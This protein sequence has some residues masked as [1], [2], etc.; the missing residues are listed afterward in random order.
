MSEDAP[1]SP[2]LAAMR[3]ALAQAEAASAA[4]QARKA[5]EREPEP[6][7]AH[8]AWEAWRELALEEDA[9]E[10]DED[11]AR[12]ARAAADALPEPEARS[13]DPE[14]VVWVPSEAEAPEPWYEARAR[15]AL[16][17]SARDVP[18]AGTVPGLLTALLVEL[19]DM[20]RTN[21]MIVERLAR[22]E[23]RAERTN[24]LLAD[25]RARP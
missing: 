14:E 19:G 24:R 17:A 2:A 20:K 10:P 22:L 13:G 1:L 3:E 4:R 5:H 11:W 6:A 15:A 25:R 12:W 23:E 9:A 21:A 16:P 7:D 8:A 18:G